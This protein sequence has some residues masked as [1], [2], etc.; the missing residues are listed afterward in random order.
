MQSKIEIKQIPDIKVL[1]LT[2]TGINGIEKTFEKLIKVALP[3]VIKYN[4]E[5]KI[6]RIFY[7]SFKNTDPNQVRMFVFLTTKE[8]LTIHPEVKQMTIHKGKY[9]IGH[10]EITMT[11]FAQTWTELFN[12]MKENGYRKRSDYPFEIYQ[13]DF[14]EHPEQKFIVDFYIP[15]A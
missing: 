5:T 6:G 10:Y 13:N 9:I 8:P 1:G 7:D 4:P 15:I 12:W 2:H 11:E 14:R 3:K